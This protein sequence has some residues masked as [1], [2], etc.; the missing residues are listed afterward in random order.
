MILARLV[1]CSI[2]IC[3]GVISSAA[4]ADTNHSEQ[5][6]K[7]NTAIN[8]NF[9]A[10][11]PDLS[12]SESSE[13]ENFSAASP[14]LSEP[15][16][17]KTDWQNTWHQE[18]NSIGAD[19]L[20]VSQFAE[21]PAI[22]QGDSLENHFP[23]LP[24]G[25]EPLE[26]DRS[27]SR[28]EAGEGVSLQNYR[29][30]LPFSSASDLRAI[31]PEN[32]DR[33]LG[34][35]ELPEISPPE[36]APEV[37]PE[38]AA[39]AEPPRLPGV[40]GDILRSRATILTTA[41]Q[42]QRGEVLTFLRYRQSLPSGTAADVGLTGQPTFG[43]SWGVTDN[44]E[45][46]FDAQTIDNSGPVEQ[47]EFR[48]QRTTS[49]GS[50]NFFQEVTLQGKQRIW[51]SPSGREALSGAVAIS[52]GVRSYQFYD[53]NFV[54]LTEGDNKQDIVPSLEL[55][56]TH[57][58]NGGSQ[59]TISP[60]V[61]FLPEDNALYFRRPPVD[62]PGSFGTTVGLAAGASFPLNSR[63]VLWG[64]AFVPF[65]GRNTIDRD[66]GLPARSIAFNAGLRYLVNPRLAADFIVSNALGNTGALSAIAD[67]EF[68]SIGGSLTYIPGFTRANREYPQHFGATLQPP[69]HTPAGFAFFDGGTVPNQQLL[70]T[71]QGGSQGILTALR[72]GLLDDFEVNIFLD[73]ISGTEDE[74]EFG[75]GTKIR[76]LHQADGDPFTLSA[77]FTASRSNNVLVN[78]LSGNRN[79]FEERNL[80]KRGFAF[81]NEA[82]SEDAGVSGNDGECLI[83]TISAPM[84]YQFENGIALW[85]TPT[86]GFVQRNGLEIGGFNVGGSVPLSENF[87][88][89]AEAGLDLT[90]K[91]NAVRGSDRETV[92]PWSVGFRWNPS[93]LFGMLSPKG[94][95][96]LQVEAYVTNRVGSTPFHNLRA[97]AD[98][99]LA[100]GVGLM[101]PIQ[102]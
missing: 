79:E 51:Q 43:F 47:G 44:L 61:V 80:K 8:D 91:G 75:I 38:N 96:G 53:K 32:F 45:V 94:T 85:L 74:S 10:A 35:S 11:S 98:N 65:A 100:V 20:P 84:H 25:E 46:T 92:I 7:K 81:S 31:A 21:N 19:R 9:L 86:L 22:S 42:L 41:H 13:N 55:P 39:T 78:F 29:Q 26:G 3:M 67:K 34:F 37:S 27:P 23:I 99:D 6:A 5:N 57:T 62:D 60:K 72:Y 77:L 2:F 18:N 83:A 15:D 95:P 54:P 48:G 71:I 14:D 50:G 90:G 101:F 52:R 4:L 88:L 59:F 102:F 1:S 89:I 30:S 87:N 68:I 40:R 24:A 76:L 69:P 28:P 17:T 49:T 12:E 58:T 97:R 64:D 82:C 93:S 36:G 16:P 56:F 70:T 33:I 73:S 66:T 63:L